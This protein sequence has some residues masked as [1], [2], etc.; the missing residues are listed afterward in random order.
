MSC[1]IQEAGPQYGSVPA[2]A[3]GL[4]PGL[5]RVMSVVAEVEERSPQTTPTANE[6]VGLIE[7]EESTRSAD[8]EDDDTVPLI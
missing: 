8:L 3:S 2:R 7:R 4:A 1:I 5:G 6:R